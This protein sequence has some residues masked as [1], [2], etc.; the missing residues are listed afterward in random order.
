MT[1]DE[2]M[3]ASGVVSDQRGKGG[4]VVKY[5]PCPHGQAAASCRY[6]LDQ[7]NAVLAVQAVHATNLWEIAEQLREI[8]A[9][10][11][12]GTS[13]Y[14]SIRSLLADVTARLTK[15]ETERT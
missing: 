12:G 11:D 14:W 4:E 7:R 1:R 8:V 3:A 2:I 9:M 5:N 6:C 10:Q 15:L 13:P